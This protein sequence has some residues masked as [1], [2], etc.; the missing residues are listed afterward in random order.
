MHW[1]NKENYT[2]QEWQT[3]LDEHP[4]VL[5]LLKWSTSVLY[6]P[7]KN[8]LYTLVSVFERQYGSGPTM[9]AL[10][11]G[12]M[13]ACFCLHM[14]ITHV[15]HQAL[16]SIFRDLVWQLPVLAVTIGV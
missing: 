7:Y 8:V 5:V 12:T 6:Y 15:H 4:K 2:K 13:Q 9:K 1:F 16:A 11:K 3:W 10:L 14:A